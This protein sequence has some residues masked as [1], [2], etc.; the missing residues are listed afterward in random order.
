QE[1]LAEEERVKRKAEKKKLKKKKQKDRKKREKLGQEQKSQQEPEAVG[2]C[3]LEG[4]FWGKRRT[5]GGRGDGGE[6]FLSGHPPGMGSAQLC[7]PCVSPQAELD[8]NCT[9]VSKARQKAGVRLPAPSKEPPATTSSKRRG[10]R[11]PEKPHHLYPGDTSAGV[12]PAGRGNEAAQ[13]GCYAEAV[14]AFTAALRL[15]PVEHRL[16]GNR[17]FCYERLQRYEEALGDALEALRLRPGWLKGLFRKGKALRGLQRYAEAANTFAELLQLNGTDAE[18]GTQLAACRALLP[19]SPS[20]VSPVTPV[21]PAAAQL[22]LTP[23]FPRSRAAWGRS[24][25]RDT[26]TSGFITVMSSRNQA[27]GQGQPAATS[28]VM[29][30]VT[31]PARDCYPLWVGNITPRIT[32]T[33]LHRTF[34]RFGEIRFIRLLPGRHCAFVNFARKKAAEAAFT[35]MQDAELEDARLL[36]QLKHPSHATPSPRQHS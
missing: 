21:T 8:L 18:A 27:R 9:F 11:V 4:A 14:Q 29:L 34:G 28:P 19:V 26:D 1:L 31:H 22:G 16:F 36:L 10:T 3:S 5:S 33:V 30:P 35:A 12:L 7:Q 24:P 13:H 25:C 6:G 20:L 2:G 32:E 23:F 17:S 15:N